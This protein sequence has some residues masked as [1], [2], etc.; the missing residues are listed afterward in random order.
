M[1]NQEWDVAEF[2]QR[3]RDGEFDGQLIESLNALSPEQTEELQSYL[4]MDGESR[5]I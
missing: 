1:S 5:S 3:F 2:V 4:L